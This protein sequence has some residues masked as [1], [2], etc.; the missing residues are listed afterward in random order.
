MKRADKSSE[1]INN[2]DQIISKFSEN[3]ILNTQ[4]MS[5]IRGG[6]ADGE[7]NGGGQIIIIPK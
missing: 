1:T 2:F 7:G 6:S 4:A 3:E 5:C